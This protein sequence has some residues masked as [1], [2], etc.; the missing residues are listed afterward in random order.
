MALNDLSADEYVGQCCPVWADCL[1][2]FHKSVSNI[3]QF[4]EDG[5]NNRFY[6]GKSEEVRSRLGLG[7]GLV[8]RPIAF[9]CEINTAR[10]N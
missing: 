7:L 8:S 10:S 9:P 4:W 1:S 5:Q 6:V 3:I 2:V